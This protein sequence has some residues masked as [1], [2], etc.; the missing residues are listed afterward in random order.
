[1]N[2]KLL[3]S[4]REEKKLTQEQMAMELG[5]KDKSS[6]CLIEKGKVKVNTETAAKIKN[7]L[8]LSTTEFIEIFFDEEVK[9]TK[10]SEN[11]TA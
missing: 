1:M 3:V 9:E 8:N 10:T 6:Y 5:Y 11:Q 2:L 7:I 4:K